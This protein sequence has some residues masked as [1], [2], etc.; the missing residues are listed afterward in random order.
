MALA[1]APESKSQE[2]ARL[3]PLF[4]AALAVAPQAQREHRIVR[5]DH[6]CEP[7]TTLPH[8]SG[9]PSPYLQGETARS[10]QL[11]V[12]CIAEQA[13]QDPAYWIWLEAH[14]AGGRVLAQGRWSESGA[15]YHVAVI[16]AGGYARPLAFQTR[17]GVT[18]YVKDSRLL[19]T[20]QDDLLR[21]ECADELYHAL[22]RH[23]LGE[24][25]DGGRITEQSIS[26]A[27]DAVIECAW[28]PTQAADYVAESL[29][30]ERR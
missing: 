15:H 27:M 30:K 4:R 10:L 24:L 12:Q 25:A 20:L 22:W 2:M 14:R 19:T 17:N 26:R 1:Y 9:T 7:R 8:Q 3:E 16:E 29:V 5:L 13:T 23:G 18:E 21:D 6:S 28:T 11:R